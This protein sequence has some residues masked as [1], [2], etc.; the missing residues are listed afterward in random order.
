MKEDSGFSRS[1]ITQNFVQ[2]KLS[3]V[4][5][6]TS[7]EKCPCWLSVKGFS[8]YYQLPTFVNSLIVTT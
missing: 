4:H 3:F 8:K 7:P 5:Q 1:V 2:Q 6:V